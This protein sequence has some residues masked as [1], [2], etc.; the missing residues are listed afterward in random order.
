MTAGELRES[1]RFDRRA[2]V[3]DDGYG[4]AQGDWATFAGPYPARIATGA[5]SEETLADG[6]VGLNSVE[7]IVRYCGA[8]ASVGS[9]DRAVNT[10]TGKTYN[11]LSTVNE[12]EHNRYLTFTAQS[13]AA[14]G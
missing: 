13:G 3:T 10:R 5:G 4:N 12:D 14:D 11:I 6:Q 2:E 8:A 7:I 9:G 1:I